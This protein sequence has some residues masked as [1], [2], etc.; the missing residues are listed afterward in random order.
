[1]ISVPLRLRASV[2][3]SLTALAAC[4]LDFDAFD[5]RLEAAVAGAGGIPGTGGAGGG[6]GGASTST[7]GGGGTGGEGG[8]PPTPGEVV[9]HAASNGWFR[10]VAA[11]PDGG[12]IAAGD[13]WDTFSFGGPPLVSA[14]EEDG[15]VVRLGPDCEHLFSTRMGSTGAADGVEAVAVAPDGG[16]VVVGSFEL[17][18]DFGPFAITSSGGMDIFVA[19]LDPTGDFVWV[20]TF[21]GAGNEWGRSVAVDDSG[22]IVVGARFTGTI[23]VGGDLHSSQGGADVLVLRLDGGGSPQWSTSFGSAGNEHARSIALSPAGDVL[24]TGRYVGAMQVGTTALAHV[25]DRDAYVAELD[26]AGVPQWARGFSS[27]EATSIEYAQALAV[28]PNGNLVLLG[29]FDTTLDFGVAQLT[30][31]GGRDVFLAELDAAGEPIWARAFGGPSDERVGALALDAAGNIGIAGALSAIGDLGGGPVGS[32]TAPSVFG[33]LYDA[34]GQLMWA[35]VFEVPGS[36]FERGLGAAFATNGDLVV[37]G[38]AGGP[39]DYG[40]SSSRE[41]GFLVRLAP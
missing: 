40:D 35:R 29:R 17:P 38:H 14:G 16:A 24:L 37:V 33:A 3:L 22:D 20:Q 4:A 6:E 39:I 30:S 41:D 34:T 27:P 8:A 1:M 12:V 5:P 32:A 18:S 31:H 7:G 21:G 26:G 15:M 25:G 11:H 36:V 10:A 23:T 19:R 9:C 28:R 13:F 2:A